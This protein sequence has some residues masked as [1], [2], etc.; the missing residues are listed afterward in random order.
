MK[1]SRHL[2]ISSIILLILL[3]AW[4]IL[5]V[6]SSPSGSIEEQ[7]QWVSA[8]VVLY[9]TQFFL[10]FLIA[11]AIIYMMLVQIRW[12]KSRGLFTCIGLIFLSAYAV[13]VSIAYGSQAMLIPKLLASG[14]TEQARVWYFGAPFSITFFIDLTGYFFWALGTLCI[15]STL[16]FRKGLLMLIGILYI[17]AAV[18]SIV[19]FLGLLFESKVMVSMTMPSGL[20]I[21]PVAVITLIAGLRK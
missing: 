3:I 20:L 2:I 6:I 19:A 17:L 7:L 15:F 21:I 14:L 18:L 1:T 12:A 11:P 10:A 5:M 8:N 16:I 9:K 13:L 4:P